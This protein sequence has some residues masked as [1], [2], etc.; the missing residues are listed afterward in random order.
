[1]IGA[2]AKNRVIGKN[3]QLPWKIPK[4]LAYF[5]KKTKGHVMIMGRK[6]YESIGKPLPQRESI[7]LSR[8]A[9]LEFPGVRVFPSLKRA[10]DDLKLHGASYPLEEVFVTGGGEIYAQA[11]PL[12]DR[13]YLT[14]IDLIV[15]DGDAFFP[16]F[17]LNHWQMV[18]ETPVPA[19]DS[20]PAYT[21]YVYDRKTD[22][23]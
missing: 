13:I 6:S 20:D 3:G 10:I 11:L 19:Q 5:K 4:E 23:T 21:F 12:A 22:S 2:M 17:D 18:S 15:D 7:V 14:V 16:E 1:M 8:Q 9:D